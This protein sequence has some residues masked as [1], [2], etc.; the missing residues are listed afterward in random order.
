MRE[1]TPVR[2]VEDVLR[3]VWDVLYPGEIEEQKVTLQ[4]RSS[5]GDTPLHVMAWRKDTEGARV[6]IAAGADV[7][8]VG[9]MDQT[10]LHVAIMQDDVEMTK[11]LLQAGA[12][13]D[14]RSEFGKTAAE[15]ARK[16]GGE[17]LRLLRDAAVEQGKK[18]E[19]RR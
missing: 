16:K 4:S 11:T 6:L 3:S 14:L 10:P 5:E 7:N 13:T 18:M 9:D 12:R 17:L 1:K 15:E 8:A 2:S 19:S